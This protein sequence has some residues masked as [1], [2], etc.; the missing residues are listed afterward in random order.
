MVTLTETAVKQ[1]KMLIEEQSQ[2]KPTSDMGL[3]V[4]VIGGGCSGMSY[5]LSFESGY[6]E[7]DLVFEQDSIRIF[8]DPKSLTYLNGLTV[9]YH[10]GLNG[11]G[12]TFNNPN[13]TKSCGCGSSFSAS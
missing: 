10:G 11:S 5:K 9:D 1:L 13:S 7:D 6:N 8:I 4:G 2:N 12:F 3:R